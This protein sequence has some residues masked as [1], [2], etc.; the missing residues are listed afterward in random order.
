MVKSSVLGFPRMGANR[1]LKKLVESH[2]DG[3]LDEDKLLEGAK[4]IRALHWRLQKEKGIE[5][6]PSNDFS[7]YDQ[8]LDAVHLFGAV[9]PRYQVVV[10]SEQNAVRGLRTYFAMG[11]GY[12]TSKAAEEASS[13]TTSSAYGSASCVHNKIDV[14]SMEMKKWFDTNY[15][16]LVPEF[17]AGQTFSLDAHPKPVAEYLEAKALGI[18]TRPVI[19]GP[20]TFLLLGKSGDAA[21]PYASRFDALV[22]LDAL[23]QVYRQLFTQLYEAGVQSIQIDEPILCLDLIQDGVCPEDTLRAAYTTAYTAIRQACPNASILIATYFDEIR[24]NLS[25]I[26]ALPINALHVDLV[27]SSSSQLDSILETIPSSWSLSIGIIDGRNIWKTNYKKNL[28][29][30]NKVITKLGKD[31]VII[32]PSCSLLHTPHSLAREVGKVRPEVLDWLAFAVEKLGEIVFL[33]R[34]ANEAEL[35]DDIT[36]SVA[37]LQSEYDANQASFHSRSVS[38]LIHNQ[39]VKARVESLT[40]DMFCRKSAFPI[41]RAAQRERL[42]LPALFPTTTI[43]S[44]PQ[45]PEVR[46]A[47]ASMKSGKM[48]PEAYDTYIKAEI[49]SCVEFQES[50]G[51]DVLV[52]GEFERT[53]M[54]EYFGEHLDGYVFTSNGWVQSYGSRCVKPPI[55]FGDVSRPAPMTLHYSTY[56]QS[57]TK[58]PM[59]GMLTGPVTILQWSFVR[60][61]QPRSTTC[62]QIGLAI[63]DEVQDLE[64]AGIA[65][66]QIDEAAVREGLPLRLS[67]WKVYLTWAIDSFLLASTG[68]RD[69]TQIHSHM[70]Y[71]DFNDIFPSIQRMDTDV[72]TIENSK[73]DLKLLR[74][75]EKY[76]YT[77]E[78]GPGLYDIHSP[79]IPTVDEMVWRAEQMLKYISKDLLHLNPDCGLKTRQ[80]NETKAALINMVQV[81]KQ[82]REKYQ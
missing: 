66:I 10:D 17:I 57:L 64:R 68:V 60:D 39:D 23:V 37:S 3:K 69:D 41:R 38:P 31:R 65:C 62:H 21:K 6:I 75:F 61:D 48:T 43:G 7:L 25:L 81:A 22:H 1:D 56:A 4:E 72:L 79:R 20:L 58:R 47:R 40:P 33:T 76:G 70:C 29:T 71:S 9:P 30:I 73:S 28:E 53:D 19:L 42:A 13:S 35:K 78:I 34:A 55:I 5:I 49:A 51:L 45:T 54:V 26:T 74:A 2:W 77:N 80:W 12:Q 15:H 16:Y 67:D 32:A 82:L 27:R 24:D 8:V 36:F 44:F 46:A 50:C 18:E 14:G 11:R 59:K 63:R 52:H